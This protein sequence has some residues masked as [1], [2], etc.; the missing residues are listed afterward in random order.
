MIMREE[1]MSGR[2]EM[3]KL[4]G[5]KSEMVRRLNLSKLRHFYISFWGFSKRVTFANSFFICP[6]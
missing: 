3:K 2:E 5:N 6:F 4:E 1:K